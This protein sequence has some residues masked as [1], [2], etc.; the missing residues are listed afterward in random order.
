[1][2]ARISPIVIQPQAII[3]AIEL[4]DVRVAIGISF[5]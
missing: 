3:V 2:I 1:M 4:K 5:V